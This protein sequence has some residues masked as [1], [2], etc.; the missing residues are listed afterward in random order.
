MKRRFKD[1][2]RFRNVR[3]GERKLWRANRAGWKWLAGSREG[4]E[5]L[6]ATGRPWGCVQHAV[7]A[8]VAC[9]GCGAPEGAY[10]ANGLGNPVLRIV[11]V[12]RLETW[13]GPKQ[14]QGSV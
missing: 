14:A 13:E 5:A 12:S 4:Y 8:T 3:L 11:H 10:C 9:R 7:I 6:Q 2:R 1:V